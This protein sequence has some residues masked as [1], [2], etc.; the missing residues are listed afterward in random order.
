M[1][2]AAAANGWIDHDVVALEHLTAIKRAGADVILTY[3]ARWLAEATPTSARSPTV[4]R[5]VLRPGACEAAGCDPTRLHRR[6]RA[7]ERGAV[8]ALARGDPR[9]RQLVHPRVQGRR[10]HAVPRRPRRGAVRVGRRGHAA[11]STSSR[12][13][14]R[15]SSATPIPPSPPR[16]PRP[17]RDGTSFG[18]PTPREMKLAEAIRERVPSCERV[19]L[20]NCGTEAT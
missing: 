6:R 18:A 16:S 17:R 8:R 12:A 2:K 9:R 1:I 5:H 19:R 4:D 14:A 10:R 13:T 3:L 20:M 11:T 15:S 7:V